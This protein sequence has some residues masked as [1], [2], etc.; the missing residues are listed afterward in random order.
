M[1]DVEKQVQ[2]DPT[3]KVLGEIIWR[4][5]KTP[6]AKSLVMSV[7][8]AALKDWSGDSRFREHISA[9]V[10][11]TIDHVLSMGREES[12]IAEDAS[13]AESL[14]PIVRE[15]VE[16][17]DF[18]E[19]KEAADFHQE[20]IAAAVMM[21][22][23]ELW[24]YPAKVICLLSLVPAVV[25]M[26]V[27]TAKESL[28]PINKLAPDLLADVVFSLVD[29]IDGKNIGRLI[30][31]LAELVRKIHT[32]STLLG[33]PGKPQLPYTLSRL[34]GETMSTVDIN[35]LLKVRKLLAE[36]KEVSLKAFIDQL[37]QSPELSREFFQDHF[38]SV[39]AFIRNW[40]RKADAFERLFSEEDIAREFARG[41]GEIDAQEVANTIS[42]L[43]GIVN[44][45][46]AVTP[47]VIKNTLSQ[48]INA[49]DADEAG[50]TV[51]WLTED[52]VESL[53][54]VAS[55]V[56]PPVIRGI[57]DLLRPEPGNGS[58]EIQEALDYLKKAMNGKEAVI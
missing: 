31:E 28:V 20:N 5:A 17:I 6:P 29:N 58:A 4:V 10:E 9:N 2:T 41:M 47:G 27:S 49:V 53:K 19:I 52:I 21:I 23:E 50:E 35:L 48:A 7:V 37:D 43:C 40:S 39:V 14:R 34:T 45:V 18:G 30:N 38:L 33:E 13:Y 1:S 55:E 46:R 44:R 15:L 25:N 26:G 16:K 24:R 51:R 54:P 36:I 12:R 32:G 8:R 57:A 11:K 3:A 42:M 22:N 56:L